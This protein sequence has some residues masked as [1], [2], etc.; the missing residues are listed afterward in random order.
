MKRVAIWYDEHGQ[1]IVLVA[2]SMIAML[3]M[4]GLVLDG[5]FLLVHRRR[6]QNAADAATLA[7]SRELALGSDDATILSRIQEYAITRNGADSVNALYEPG[8]ETIGQGS[9]PGTAT[10]VRVETQFQY[11]TFFARIVG[12]NTLT[13]SGVAEAQ[14]GALQSTGNLLPM[15][16]HCDAEEM[17]EE[18]ECPEDAFLLDKTYQ[19]WGTKTGPGGFGWLDWD[20]PPVG[21][22][23]LADNIRHPENSGTWQIGDF[24]RSGPGVKDSEPVRS[25]LDEWLARPED[26][27]HVTIIV[28]DYT[29][30]G[31][32]NLKYHIVGFAEFVL[33][34]YDFQGSN[35]TIT[36][37]FQKWV[38][39]SSDIDIGDTGFGAYGVKITQ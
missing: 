25:A 8:G 35:K 2:V 23:E 24:V 18:G 28:Y 15:V 27:R 33:A 16:T 32:A 37:K 10:G 19:L 20:G 22:P 14:L 3:A 36:G 38:N 34:G 11:Q 4:S 6:M 29:Q 12:Q 26:Q 9:V 31:G 21:T 1:S 17:G 13:A 39:P 7:G 30:G 5:G